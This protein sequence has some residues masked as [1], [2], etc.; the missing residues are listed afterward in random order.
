MCETGKPPG[1]RAGQWESIAAD[2]K[3][4]E[5]D[6]FEGFP[7]RLS[8][9]SRIRKLSIQE[10]N[11]KRWIGLGK[12]GRKQDSTLAYISIL[13]FANAGARARLQRTL[14]T[15]NDSLEGLQ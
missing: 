4:L 9:L 13:D 3:T 6:T 7:V 1:A 2:R 14:A 8:S 15:V 11:E 12:H 5:K 10:R